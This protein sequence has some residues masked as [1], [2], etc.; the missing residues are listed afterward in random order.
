MDESYSLKTERLSL[1]VLN[2]D[3]KELFFQYRSIP[4]IYRF[5]SWKPSTI[6][7][8]E[9]FIELNLSIIPNTP[10]TWLQLAVCLKDGRLIGD[11]GIH[12]LDDG[13]QLELGYTIAPDY[14]GRGYA[15]EAVRA[16]ID[17]LFFSLGK[18]RITASVDPGNLKSIN[19]LE[20]IGFRKEAHF[21]KSYLMNNEWCDDCVYALLAE[22]V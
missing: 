3:D 12:F 9:A 11:I 20:K 15:S 16:V 1:R 6:E 14:Q 2:M 19:L 10:S 4:E 18:H 5:Q 13:Y 22:E 17:F 7:E 8:I 21:V